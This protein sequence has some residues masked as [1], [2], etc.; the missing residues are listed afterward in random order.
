MRYGTQKH[1]TICN[2]PPK[3]AHI[4]GISLDF[5]SHISFF[6]F[7]FFYIIYIYIKQPCMQLQ[8]NYVSNDFQVLQTPRIQLYTQTKTPNSS[9]IS[10][11]Q[12][13]QA[14]GRPGEPDWQATGC[15]AVTVYVI[16]GLKRIIKNE[17]F[18]NYVV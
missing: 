5:Q 7:F 8:S 18:V 9:T 1:P 17:M 2:F 10:D 14:A 6:F 11:R 16:G 4:K 15:S 13:R 3:L 12:Y